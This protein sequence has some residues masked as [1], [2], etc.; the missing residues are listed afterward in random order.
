M[1]RLP[2]FGIR[3]Y[4]DRL[5][6]TDL[7]LLN[8]LGELRRE[9]ARVPPIR[10]LGRNI[11]L[12]GRTG[13]I[14]R[15]GEARDLS[16]LERA[17]ARH[18][19][20]VIDDDLA[21]G[22][23]DPDL[24]EPYRLKLGAFAEG[25]WPKLKA[26]ADLVIV[27]SSVLAETYG[28]KARIVPPAW[29]LPP[30]STDHF[31]GPKHLD[32]V[33]LGTGSHRGDLAM[34]VAPLARILDRHPG[35]RLTLFAGDSVPGQLRSHRHLK[36][37]RPQS[38]WR[39]KR[40]LAKMRF[41]LA[42]YPLAPSPFNAARSANK[43]FEHA[44]V[45]AAS[46]MSPNPALRAAAGPGVATTFVEGGSAEWEAKIGEHLAAPEEMRKRVEA[47]RAHIHATDPLA[48]AALQWRDILAREL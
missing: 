39:Y 41:H 11:F 33:H 4:L 13:V 16:R 27:P 5:P 9:G 7:Y 1:I 37:R 28:P 25:E 10:H 18:I 32:I 44:I 40:A 24:P 29:H 12:I 38:W 17:G 46:L 34:L 43:I 48:Y 42:I 20:Y 8:P 35:A 2:P 6:T 22:A 47:A 23:T 19:V 30:A 3:E 26:A 36:L 15:Y 31:N 14:V 21:A 45:G